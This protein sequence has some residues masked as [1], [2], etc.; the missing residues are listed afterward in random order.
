[1]DYNPQ[2]LEEKWLKSWQSTNA[3]KTQ[4]DPKKE[5]YYVLEMFPYPSGKLHMGHVR[6]YT[7]GDALAR[8]KIMEGFNVLH[9][10]G[11]DSFG[12]PAENAAIKN[13]INPLPWTQDNIDEMKSQLNRL[14][15]GYDWDREL[16]TCKK[17]YYHWNQWLFTKMV[18]KGLIYRKKGW[19]NWDPVDNTV[20]AN[21]QVIDGKGWRSG[22]DV[23]KKEIV[24]W[25][26]K[27]TD[28]AEELLTDL[29]KLDHWPE[30]V[31]AMQKNWIGK[32]FGTEI[33][34]DICD[35]DGNKL[36]TLTV[37]TTRPDT[38]FGATYVSLAP[39]H[40]FCESLLEKSPNKDKVKSFIKTAMAKSA[41]ERGDDSKTKEG[42]DFGLV[43]I[44]PVNNEPCKLYVADYV[45]M[46]YG[47]GAVMAVP[48]HDQRDF[49]FAKNHKLDM[50]VV[51]TP[52]DTL[53]KVEDLTEAY[54]DNGKL[55]DSGQFTGQ[56]NTEAK[57][58][59]T[60][61]LVSKKTGRKKVQYRLRDWLISRQRYW[62]TPIPMLY[63]EDGNTV[64]V[65]EEN[66]PV[67][68]PTD[69]TFDGKGNPLESSESFKNVK[70]DGKSYTR[71]TDTMDTFFDSSWYF[72]RFCDNKNT[73]LPFD[74]DKAN[75]WM[76]VDQYIGG[77]EHAILHLLYARF[78]T[79]VCRDLGLVDIDEP[80]NRLLCQ[81]MVL[82][83]GSKMSKS[84]G[85]TVDP[86]AIIKK[87]G[88]DTARLFI[89]FG[90]P[91]ERDLDWSDTGVEGS[92]RF[93]K[94]LHRLCACS[95]E[96]PLTDNATLEKQLNK[97][98]KAV[99]E[100][101]NRFSFNTAISRL[102]ELV[103]TMYQTGV[104]PGS[105]KILVQ[106]LAPF[107]PF[108]AEEL[109]QILSKDG[110]SVHTSSWPSFDESKTVDNEVTIVI[111]VNGKVRAKINAARDIAKED[112]E[113]QAFEDENVKKYLENGS[114]L[115]C[116][117]IPNKLLNLVIK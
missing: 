32:S 5:N 27:I 74:K 54:T 59:I 78:F 24:Q 62:G 107:A 9:P 45:L 61:F 90:A 67:E 115:K 66:L 114:L 112:I 100:D 95:N 101:I 28:Y 96:F 92:F 41:I 103:N 111:Q 81:G 116:I 7:I 60:D 70:Q 117:Y 30:R 83:D 77:I 88:A 14:G 13:K 73:S 85:N 10:M 33:D 37:F 11:F 86:D 68:L 98:V 55:V 2:E 18:D 99:T 109:W 56:K 1:M 44:N 15:L 104:N 39:E 48:T 40:P 105:L 71:E 72:L 25:Y 42:V 29:D 35:T 52:E 63:N 46:D 84:V 26:I 79:K 31:K 69:V 106:C 8:F 22:A 94:R 80:F 12:L 49:E 53:L 58:A 91:V 3:F 57:A 89:L 50:K 34:F 4:T 64:T 108:L 87:Y 38:L 36:E 43:A 110:S 102:M 23:E 51:I 113:K 93:L 76:G 47:T 21:E 20:L 6:N 82:K 16:A 17:D 97:T 65:K 75:A 19:V